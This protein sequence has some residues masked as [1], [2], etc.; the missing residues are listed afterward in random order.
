M[1]KFVKKVLKT[2]FYFLLIFWTMAQITSIFF[3]DVKVR[4]G[5]L[6]LGQ[7]YDS[8]EVDSQVDENDFKHIEGEMMK[9]IN[10]DRELQ[11]NKEN[12]IEIT[13]KIE[14]TSKVTENIAPQVQTQKNLIETIKKVE[15]QQVQTQ[16]KPTEIQVIDVTEV[17]WTF[18]KPPNIF[19]NESLGEFG[20]GV[21]M[22]KS[23][24]KDIREIYN[25]GKLK[26]SFNQYLSDLISFHRTLPDFRTEYCKKMVANYS[27]NMPKTSIIII[28]HNEAW[29][30]LLRS[31]HSVLDRSPEN[32][33]EEVILVDDFS[34]MGEL[35]RLKS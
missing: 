4:K 12:S 24:P 7:M 23:L 13:E 33:I 21:T 6:K 32:L 30:T 11:L 28:F 35:G 20:E 17:K 3:D 2:L 10:E 5:G 29:S 31:V 18:Q 34:E 27:S 25:D 16:P 26:N 14:T 15:I 22:P 9:R 19:D 1:F 8:E